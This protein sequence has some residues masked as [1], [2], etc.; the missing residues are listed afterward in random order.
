MSRIV[1]YVIAAVMAMKMVMTLV[2]MV[3]E[4]RRTHSLNVIATDE[5]MENQKYTY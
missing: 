4:F 2:C 5:L 3:R 1:V